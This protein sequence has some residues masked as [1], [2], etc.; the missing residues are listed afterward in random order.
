[1]RVG[2]ISDWLVLQKCESQLPMLCGGLG[3]DHRSRSAPVGFGFSGFSL[4]WLFR[5]A[6]LKGFPA[7]DGWSHRK[8][9][10]GTDLVIKSSSTSHHSWLSA[11]LPVAWCSLPWHH[12]GHDLKQ[13]HTMHLRGRHSSFQSLRPLP[14]SP[15]IHR[16]FILGTPFPPPPPNVVTVTYP[17]RC[18]YPQPPSNPIKANKTVQTPNGRD[19]LQ[20]SR[21]L[22]AHYV[23][24]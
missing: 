18:P 12:P 22:R 14:Y 17:S 10:P 23:D 7:K 15:S 16:P 20:Q 5:K 4:V 24:N 9:P 6:F 19:P 2:L 3:W 1:M 13:C 11:A 8:C 21:K